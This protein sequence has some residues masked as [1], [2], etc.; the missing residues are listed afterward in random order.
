MR[1]GSDAELERRHWTVEMDS[2]NEISLLTFVEKELNLKFSESELFSLHSSVCNLE[3][4]VFSLQCSA[5]FEREREK[6]KKMGGVK[7]SFTCTGGLGWPKVKG[8]P[9]SEDEDGG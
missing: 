3:S 1:N 9:P 2:S 6:E 5:K 4:A 7:A 8:E